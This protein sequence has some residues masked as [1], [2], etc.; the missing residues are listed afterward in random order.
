[1]T[2]KDLIET[3]RR[4]LSLAS[5]LCQPLPQKGNIRC[6]LPGHEDKHASFHVDQVR[7]RWICWSHPNGRCSGSSIDLLM[8]MKNLDFK[9]AVREGAHSLGLTLKPMTPAE[10]EAIATARRREE[11]L[12]LLARWGVSRLKGDTSDA[13]AARAYLQRRGFEEDLLREHL[14]GL[15]SL[16][17]FALAQPQ[18]PLLC[19]LP[20]EAYWAAGLRSEKGGL[21]FRGHRLS[22]PLLRNNLAVGMTFRALPESNDKRK[23]VHLA[24]QAAGLWNLDAL[25]EREGKVVLAEGV[26]DALTLAGFGLAAVGNLGLEVARNA[27][28][29][30]HLKEVTLVWD[31]D[32]AG[33][34]RVV[35]S[36]QAIQAALKD[37]T[38]RVL[39]VPGEKDINEW[40]QAGGTKDQFLELLAAAPNLLE[41]QILRLPD[42]QASGRLSLED[43]RLLGEILAQVAAQPTLR[44]TMY[45]KMIKQRCDLPMA[46]LR[47]GMKQAQAGLS[48]S[49][50]PSSGLN[51][52]SVSEAH[53][54]GASS[55]DEEQV[56]VFEDRKPF[57]AALDFDM[58]GPIPVGHIG[59]WQDVETKSDSGTSTI[60]APYL[61]ECSMTS[62][63][64]VVEMVPASGRF[65][66][67]APISCFPDEDL[68]HWNRSET[69]P[70]SVANFLNNPV[71]CLQPTGRL[72]QDIRNLL[73]DFL[74]YPDP[75]ELD[76]LTTW[77]L[78]T[79]VFPLFESIGFLHIN[80]ISGSGKSLTMD[81]LARLTFN[82]AKSSS[83]S[84]AALFRL[85]H[86]GRATIFLDE[87]ERLS[88]PKPGTPDEDTRLSIN[89]AYK[90]SGVAR[91][92]NVETG[93]VELFR[94]FGPKCLGSIKELDATLGSR[95]II[96]RSLK[97]HKDVK[98]L[99]SAQQDQLLN[100]RCRELINRMHCWAL[101]TF[102]ELHRL[103]TK[104]LL[105]A[106]PDLYSRE[107]EIWL[108]LFTIATLV[109]RQ[110]APGASSVL[111]ALGGIQS[112]KSSERE[113][114]ARR[115][116]QDILI[117]KTVLD[118][119]TGE[120]RRMYELLMHPHEFSTKK[121]ADDVHTILLESGTWSPE[122]KF[123]VQHILAPLKQTHVIS[124][125]DHRPDRR[126]GGKRVG[127]VRLMP[128]ALEEALRRLQGLEEGE[129]PEESPAMP[130]EDHP[131]AAA[132][133]A[134]GPVVED[135]LPF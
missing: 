107:R 93:R 127:S 37:G 47:L 66:H 42:H 82:A 5:I 118:L 59:L 120:D 99:D 98:L 121:L 25:R 3:V 23:F 29:F 18:H 110:P 15:V 48:Q 76:I 77:A 8:A 49:G 94:T 10:E 39:H 60:Q 135:E 96:V 84:L 43:E 101:T 80:G 26:P 67:E 124:E 114:R 19:E 1:M 111:E 102:P 88:H 72:F 32:K 123:L 78:M 34:G 17:Q 104:E 52:A 112:I 133:E 27:Q 20:L 22:F 87:A 31:N 46:D 36:A 11:A 68:P 106:W 134:E 9:E 58:E 54:H 90:K 131:P 14:V 95:C 113:A 2:Y 100:R 64:P 63:G 86:A 79:F 108:P 55:K 122:R 70:C 50:V 83:I 75:R 97:K 73:S 130:Q 116:N 109:D 4:D 6:P 105:G 115:E 92:F 91:R 61:V 13:H 35:Q 81:I 89:D 21:L 28:Q 24:G 62:G 126:E 41:Y 125:S 117:L 65:G 12:T 38:V 40:A 74:W 129:S 69:M 128:A 57:I 103:F 56:L 7:N 53:A 51:A 85:V 30:S 16:E 44:Q 45:L 119:I 71:D 33:R 132:A